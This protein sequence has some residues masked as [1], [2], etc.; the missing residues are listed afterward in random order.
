MSLSADN[1][2]A[3]GHY[4][5]S[6]YPVYIPHH[7]QSNPAALKEYKEKQ[8]ENFIPD[9]FCCEDKSPNFDLFIEN[10]Q[11]QNVF[12][13]K[14]A[15]N[16]NQ[17]VNIQLALQE[18]D[19]LDHQ[20]SDT[21]AFK[22]YNTGRVENWAHENE[23]LGGMAANFA[24]ASVFTGIVKSVLQNN[25]S[26][27][28]FLMKSLNVFHGFLLGVR[29]KC[30]FSL[31]SREDDDL[32]VN[33]YQFNNYGNK[34][35]SNYGKFAC[36]EE[37]YINPFLLPVIGLLDT[38]KRDAIAELAMLPNM[39]WWRIRYAGYINQRCGDYLLK[40]ITHK[41]LAVLGDKD[42]KKI[43]SEINKSKILSSGYIRKRIKTYLGLK[44]NESILK[45]I[46]DLTTQLFSEDIDE[47]GE[48]SVRL[49]SG[50]APV[51]GVSAFFTGLVGIPAKAIGKLCGIKNRFL[52]S[53]AGLSVFFQ[54]VLYTFGFSVEQYVDGKKLERALSS[55]KKLDT[56]TKNRF[57]NVASKKQQLSIIGFASNILGISLPALK[58]FNG[59]NSQFVKITKSL[60]GELYNSTVLY[61]FS[62]RRELKAKNAKL[63]ISRSKK[64]SS[65]L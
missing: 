44:D 17:P 26:T 18:L 40:Y 59:E 13:A 42:S 20:K 10:Q 3:T 8:F 12:L 24:L 55:N 2:A 63:E 30:Q 1:V 5:G 65:K 37:K 6:P 57:K 56:K 4:S 48:A 43:I 58:L 23:H 47:V 50:L 61:F 60:I 25:E 19:Q 15:L 49:R 22:K 41:P 38:E 21:L 7:I 45:G 28:M 51:L 32:G 35:S 14:Q 36:T 52:D 54:Q 27:P 29:G 16:N 11:S 9:E 34:T 33:K 46:K 31:Y 62:K 53:F 64:H 39:L